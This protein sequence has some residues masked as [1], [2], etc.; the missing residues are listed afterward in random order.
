MQSARGQIVGRKKRK[1][2]RRF[3]AVAAINP[4][5]RVE[6]SVALI[7]SGHAPIARIPH[8]DKLRRMIT[9]AAV[10]LVALN[11]LSGGAVWL[12]LAFVAFLD[13]ALFNSSTARK[14]Y[15]ESLISHW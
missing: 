4:K 13:L 14:R 3:F 11:P 1:A 5:L 10:A 6:A 9:V 2:T 8:R 12:N 7:E 15:L